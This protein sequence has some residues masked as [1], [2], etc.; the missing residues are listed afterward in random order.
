MLA[1]NL[2]RRLLRLGGGL[3]TAGFALF[4]FI[5]QL[6]HPHQDENNHPVIFDKYDH[7][8]PGVRAH[9]PVPRRAIALGGFVALH[10][11]LETR[12][13]DVILARL[14][15]GATI[16]TAAV[17]A[18]LQAVDGTALKEATEAWAHAS[19][20][21][22]TARFADAET[23]RWT[24]WGFQSYFRL[25]MGIT[26]ILNGVCSSAARRPRRRIG[27]RPGRAAVHDDRRR[28]RPH[29]PRQARRPDRATADADLRRRHRRGRPPSG[30]RVAAGGPA[31]PSPSR[32]PA[33]ALPRRRTRAGI[34]E[35]LEVCRCG[36]Y[37]GG[38]R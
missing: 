33:C 25:L 31:R 17:W 29:R 20:A 1:T 32:R 5:T 18:V 19:G 36:V 23:V 14:A 4:A 27:R 35:N 2:E 21:E 8:T 26:F 37:R 28:G 30:D 12:G 9:R 7:R 11:L 38:C 16:A 13:T 15:L 24:E 6:F 3:L 22:K 34:R 10:R